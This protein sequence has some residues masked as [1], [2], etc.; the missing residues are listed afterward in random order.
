GTSIVEQVGRRYVVVLTKRKQHGQGRLR[1]TLLKVGHRC[2]THTERL[3]GDALGF[4]LDA[5]T[6]IEQLEVQ[7]THGGRRVTEAGNRTVVAVT[8]DGQC[9]DDLRE[10]NT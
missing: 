4:A 8:G 7:T 6:E 3:G 9:D 2:R 10:S 1:T 5:G